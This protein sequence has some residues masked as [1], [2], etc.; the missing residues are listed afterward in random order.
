[1]IV[2]RDGIITR[3][4]LSFSLI[5]IL[6]LAFGSGIK[7]YASNLIYGM[8][9]DEPEEVTS[10]DGYK[11]Q[12]FTGRTDSVSVTVSAPEGAIPAG[13]VMKVADVTDT[14]N[15]Q[16]IEDAVAGDA[17]TVSQCQF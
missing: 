1:M 14:S 9:F 11:V 15:L 8:P 10:S 13:T 2:R 16:V 17:R 6:L 7:S 3:L 5:L 12:T 4:L